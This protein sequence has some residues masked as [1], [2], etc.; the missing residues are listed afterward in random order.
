MIE[1]QFDNQI[2]FPK[3]LERD[4]DAH[5]PREITCSFGLYSWIDFSVCFSASIC[6]TQTFKAAKSDQDQ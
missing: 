4:F 3:N 2:F 5:R 6:V 1:N